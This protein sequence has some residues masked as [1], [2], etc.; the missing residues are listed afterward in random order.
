MIIKDIDKLTEVLNNIRLERASALEI[1]E[2][3]KREETKLFTNLRRAKITL[4]IIRGW[5]LISTANMPNHQ[6]RPTQLVVRGWSRQSTSN[7]HD[8][9]R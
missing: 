7:T 1:L 8:L 3:T 2:R 5:W 4:L 9:R 6:H